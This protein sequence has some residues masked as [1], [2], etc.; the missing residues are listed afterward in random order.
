MQQ[1]KTTTMK[2]FK[3]FTYLNGELNLS[4]E[5]VEYLNLYWEYVWK[6]HD[7]IHRDATEYANVNSN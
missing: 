4:Q 3:T 1:L 5:R 7:R 6:H 2:A